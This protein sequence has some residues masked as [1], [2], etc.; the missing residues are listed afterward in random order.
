MS[1]LQRTHLWT[2]FKSSP[3]QW[4]MAST[5]RASAASKKKN[6]RSA[7]LPSSVGSADTSSARFV[8]ADIAR[9]RGMV[10]GAAAAIFVAIVLVQLGAG[11]AG[12]LGGRTRVLPHVDGERAANRRKEALVIP[13]N[14][15]KL[16]DET[17]VSTAPADSSSVLKETE[18]GSRVPAANAHFDLHAPK[19]S[20]TA[21]APRPQTLH[22]LAQA[23]RRLWHAM[24]RRMGGPVS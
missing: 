13:L 24:R 7:P 1:D 9:R 10:V 15:S 4:Q 21:P 17:E 23:P 6:K 11:V 2:R 12:Q 16:D 20:S 19:V 18:M 22:R 3:W 8:Q 14:T 5:Q